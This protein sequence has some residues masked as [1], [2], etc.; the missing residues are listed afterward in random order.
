MLLYQVTTKTGQNIV[1]EA[2]ALLKDSTNNIWSEA[3]MLQALKQSVRKLYPD[4]FTP[5]VDTSL[6]TDGTSFSFTIPSTLDLIMGVQLRPSSQDQYESIRYSTEW[7]GSNNKLN[8]YDKYQSG[9]SIKLLGGTRLAVPAALGDALDVPI[10]AEDLLITAIKMEC[11]EMLLLDKGKLNQFAAREQG[12]TEVDVINMIDMLKRD[13]TRRK[14][15]V[16]TMLIS[17][18]TRI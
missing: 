13:Y 15:E 18:M 17:L 1:D 5:K 6:S 16:A 8:L 14:D 7:D 2:E 3:E 10:D 12:V 11:M 4:I 9:L